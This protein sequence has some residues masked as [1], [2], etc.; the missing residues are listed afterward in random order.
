M[1]VQLGINE[2]YFEGDEKFEK[3][4]IMVYQLIDVEFILLQLQEQNIVICEEFNQL[5]N[6]NRMLKDRLNVLGFFLEQRLDNFEKLFGYQ[7]LSLEIIFG[8]Q[9]D[10]G[11]ILIFLVE[12]FVFGL[13]EDF[14]SQD[15]NILMDYQY[16]N[17][18]DNLDSECSE[19]YQFFILSD[20]VL[21]V[22]FFLELEGIF[23]IECFWKGS[24]GNVSEVLVV[25]LIEWIYQM[26]EN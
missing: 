13:V 6:E 26:E 15:E 25:C 9:S 16:S 17:F 24:S 5:K 4:I 11:G 20:D 22:L 19:V 1:C 8:N 2:D 12:G 18:M 7:F 10:G 23:S 21:D 3:E 14:L